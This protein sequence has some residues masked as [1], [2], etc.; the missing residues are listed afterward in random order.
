MQQRI[1]AIIRAY[2]EQGFHR[3]GT[4]IDQHSGAW[5]AGTMRQ[6]GLEPALE[7]F[8]LSRV[9]PVGASIA[10]NGRKIAG[11]PLFDGGFTDS[12]GIEGRLGSLN[13]DAPIGFAE[14]PPNAAEAGALGEARRQHRHQA[15][16]VVTRGA[17]PGFARAMPTASCDRLVLRCCRSQAR[18]HRSL[19]IARSGARRRC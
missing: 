6:I 8:P 18:K 7:E 1:G 13:G 12:A 10:V 17:R 15:I 5:L 3:T 9:D 11:L 4:A 16:I 19:P 14:I 2:E